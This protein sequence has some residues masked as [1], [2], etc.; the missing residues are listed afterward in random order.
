MNLVETSGEGRLRPG[1]EPAGGGIGL[2]VGG[3]GLGRLEPASGQIQGVPPEPQA[4]QANQTRPEPRR[5]D[6]QPAPDGQ[7]PDDLGR[8]HGNTFRSSSKWGPS[9]S[10]AQSPPQTIA[11]P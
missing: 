2:C 9:F 7:G 4:I 8:P 1:L 5:R 11:V 10:R 3:A 6:Q